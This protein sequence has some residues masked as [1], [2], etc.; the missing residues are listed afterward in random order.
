MCKQPT[1]RLQ[2]IEIRSLYL[3]FQSR[4]TTDTCRRN[5]VTNAH[6]IRISDP[7]PESSVDELPESILA[8]VF[9]LE[10]FDELRMRGEAA[11]IIDGRVA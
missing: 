4:H 9:L 11:V 10:G 7:P 5:D 8:P 1:V 2:G 6:R 3:D